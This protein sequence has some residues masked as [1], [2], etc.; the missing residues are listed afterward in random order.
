M[1]YLQVKTVLACPSLFGSVEIN[2]M[3]VPFR[4]IFSET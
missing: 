3:I 2:V 4:G 1:I